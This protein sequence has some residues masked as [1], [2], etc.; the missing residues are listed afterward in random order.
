ML[1]T[2]RHSAMNSAATPLLASLLAPPIG[3]LAACFLTLLW[4]RIFHPDTT[5]P[6]E[7]HGS[8]E[9]PLF[10]D[11]RAYYRA[12]ELV[13]RGKSPYEWS[14]YLGTPVFARILAPFALLGFGPAVLLFQ[15]LSILPWPIL[16]AYKALR[17]PDGLI[18]TFAAGSFLLTSAPFLWGVHRANVD[19][20][21]GVCLVIA[22]IALA[23]SR[24][25]LAGVFLSIAICVKYYALLLLVPLEVLGFRRAA[26]TAYAV[27]AALFFLF[28]PLDWL[29][30]FSK[31]Q[32]V[33]RL[34]FLMPVHN[35]STA[36]VWWKLGGWLGITTL[37]EG[38]SVIRTLWLLALLVP[39]VV[40]LVADFRRQSA[41]STSKV[42][43]LALYSVFFF[44][45]P[46]Q[47]Y[48]YVAVT[49]LPLFFVLLRLWN[50][51]PSGISKRLLLGLAVAL[52]LQHCHAGAL[53]LLL[54]TGGIP[55]GGVRILD[56]AGSLAAMVFVALWKIHQAFELR[57]GSAQRSP[58]VTT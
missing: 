5:I 10:R 33:E 9:F 42:E 16:A 2:L 40:S 18:V 19:P 12:A 39:F 47:I 22:F 46:R 57:S 8:T 25:R 36:Q 58:S 30:P 45:F 13:L 1:K 27:C 4:L 24:D 43:E 21:L 15:I 23:G 11:F 53:G 37:T 29:R 34:Y 55:A 14:W 50:S 56:A 32:M 44:G 31:F 41:P 48:P 52:G 7:W 20:V 54:E 3:I 51:N 49:T 17:S 28:G 26:N 38:D 35:I 6:V